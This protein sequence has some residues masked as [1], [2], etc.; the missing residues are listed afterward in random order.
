MKVMDDGEVTLLSTQQ[1]I[2]HTNLLLHCFLLT[3]ALSASVSFSHV[4]FSATWIHFA[5]VVRSVGES[6]CKRSFVNK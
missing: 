3:Q 6:V 5:L 4:A 2:V 1:S